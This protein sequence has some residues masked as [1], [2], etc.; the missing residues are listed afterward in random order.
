[1]LVGMA[2]RA[3]VEGQRPVEPAG[4]ALFA[5]DLGVAAAQ[6]EAR[7]L[8]VEEAGN[9]IVD[10]V[11]GGAVVG[12]LAVVPVGVAVAALGE[13]DVREGALGVA[14]AALDLG[15]AAVDGEGRLLVVEAGGF[16]VVD[17]V[18]G[19]AVF[20]QLAAVL[21]KVAGQAVLLEAEVAPG[22]V[23]GLAFDLGMG[24]FE[25]VAGQLVVEFFRV[26]AHEGEIAPPVVAVAFDAGLGEGGVVAFAGFE[27]FGQRRVAVEAFAVGH[28]LAEG[29]ALGAVRQALELGVVDGELARREQLGPGGD[30][31]A[32]GHEQEGEHSGLPELAFDLY[33]DRAHEIHRKLAAGE[34]EDEIVF[35]GL[36]A[37]ARL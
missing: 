22:R 8:V 6:L 24:P 25:G 18:A 7:A 37:A 5:L 26:P 27:A 3:A 4:V 35:Q 30:G 15:V 33:A 17:G 9:E 2:V 28:L 31:Q 36:Q 1:M 16:P 12:E 19:Q 32:K 14:L 21:V 34:D 13:G 29:V 10:G 23:A 11:A 20:A